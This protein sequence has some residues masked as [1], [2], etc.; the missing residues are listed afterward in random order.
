VIQGGP[1]ARLWLFGFVC[2]LLPFV[3]I[4]LAF[5]AA[6]LE[7]HIDWCV[8]Y[9]EGCS[10]ISRGG[11]RGTGYF[12][13]KGGMLPTATLLA[14]FWYL[15]RLWLRALGLPGGRS[16]PWLGLVASVSLV[17]YTLALGHAGDL[18]QL[19]RRIGVIGWF[20]LTWLGQLVLARAL[21]A[22][23]G[24]GRSAQR[25]VGVSL[26]A[27]L[28]GGASL[29]LGLAIPDRH[30]GLE[31]TFEWVL[32]LLLTAHAAAT[33]MLWRRSAFVLRGHATRVG[34]GS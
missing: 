23:A 29:V 19:T 9:W 22:H 20:A 25:L 14:L 3:T 5:L 27:M 33:A 2:A 17:L 10:S 34:P 12:I 7:G 11:R 16:L 1:P 32:A 18:F 8:P 6:T 26:L 13:F 30:D 31:D 15:C 4:H 24:L 28:V 21:L